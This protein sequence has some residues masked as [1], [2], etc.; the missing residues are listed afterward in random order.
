M[1]R[2]A[3]DKT[4]SDHPSTSTPA[5]A[6][7]PDGLPQL[8]TVK[9]VAAVLRVTTRTVHRLIKSGQLPKLN[10]GR[11]VRV[12]ASALGAVIGPK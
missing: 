12:D 5:A 3:T 2:S 6:K 4:R 11:S 1:R 9:E 8:L 7:A 10:I